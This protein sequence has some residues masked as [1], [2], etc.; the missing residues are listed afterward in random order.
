MDLNQIVTAIIYGLSVLVP[1]AI[2]I[3]TL[4]KKSYVNNSIKMITTKMVQGFQ[5]NNKQHKEI[6]E[7]L[8]DH[9][10]KI[11]KLLQDKN[12]ACKIRQIAKHAIQYCGNRQYG[13]ILDAFTQQFIVFVQDITD[14]GF[15]NTNKQQIIAKLSVAR[16]NSNNFA[17][18]ILNPSLIQNWHAHTT[19]MVQKYL[20]EIFQIYEDTVNNK[21]ARFLVKSEDFAQSIV[22]QFI[23]FSAKL[24]Y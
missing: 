16:D 6:K 24:T 17:K 21:N 19:P 15:E 4:I 10:C 3:L 2:T 18:T 12:I 14:I 5:N 22:R 9:T 13:K 11:Q 7:T 8:I 20:Q 1:G 23:L